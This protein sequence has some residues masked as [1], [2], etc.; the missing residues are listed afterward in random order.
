MSH[1]SSKSP[2]EVIDVGFDL[3]N[4]VLNDLTISTALIDVTIETGTANPS[5]LIKV[6][7]PSIVGKTVLQ[8]ISQGVIANTYMLTLTA[9]ASNGET[10]SEAACIAVEEK[11]C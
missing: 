8:R 2:S 7:S 9:T 6:G 4:L 3:S 10:F 11:L 1:F 5:T